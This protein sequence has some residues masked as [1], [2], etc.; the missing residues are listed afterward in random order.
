MVITDPPPSVLLNI[1]SLFNLLKEHPRVATNLVPSSTSQPGQPQTQP[2]LCQ[3]S[4]GF[5]NLLSMLRP[6]AGHMPNKH[7]LTHQRPVSFA[8]PAALL[9][10][11]PLLPRRGRS[12]GC[13]ECSCGVSESAVPVAGARRVQVVASPLSES[14]SCSGF[15]GCAGR[16]EKGKKDWCLYHYY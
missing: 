12:A 14:A 8:R 5:L 13:A 10:A 1:N 9:E 16:R 7:P 11:T 3:F 15:A 4:C 2:L 6:A